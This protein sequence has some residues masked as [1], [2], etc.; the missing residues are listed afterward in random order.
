MSE[1]I[2][3][4]S[5]R[6]RSGRSAST[7]RFLQWAAAL[8][9]SG[10]LLYAVA[11]TLLLPYLRIDRVVVQADFEIDRALLLRRAGLSGVVHFHTVNPEQVRRSLETIPEIRRVVVQKTFPDTIRLVM[12]RRRPLLVTLLP[13]GTGMELAVIDQDGVIYQRGVSPENLDLPLISGITFQ[14]EIVGSRLPDRLVSVIE[15]IQTLRVEEPQLFG[16]LSEIRVVP[17]EA[18]AFDLLVYNKSFRVP[19]RMGRDLTTESFAYSLMILD[20]LTQQ[21]VADSVEE[22]DFRSGEIVYRLKEDESAR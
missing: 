14:G 17:R 22:I 12:E 4:R 21:G 1:A 15:R 8:V 2:L 18:G 5:R 20:V 9:G 6:R 16:A 3:L 10:A 13:D 7:L 19:V 11:T